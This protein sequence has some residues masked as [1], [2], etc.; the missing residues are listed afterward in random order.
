MSK[1]KLIYLILLLL[2]AVAPTLTWAQTVNDKLIPQVTPLTLSR[3][4]QLTVRVGQWLLRMSIVLALIVLTVGG[5]TFMTAGPNMER[6]AMAK[7]IILNGIIGSVIV[8]GVG[9]L[10]QTIN[11]FFNQTFFS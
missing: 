7:K 4:E 10:L 1:L 3:T 5:I 2:V 11:S 8:M 9:L 6:V